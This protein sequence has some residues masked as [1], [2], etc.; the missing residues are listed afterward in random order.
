M[1]FFWFFFSFPNTTFDLMPFLKPYFLI[2]TYR[3]L[4]APVWAL[5]ILGYACDEARILLTTDYASTM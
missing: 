3:L 4:F 1:L 2:Y 5:A